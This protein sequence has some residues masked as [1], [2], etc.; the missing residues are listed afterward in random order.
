MEQPQIKTLNRE[1]LYEQVWSKPMIKLAREYG[2]SDNGLRNICR[3]LNVPMP[4]SGYWQQLQYGCEV[5]REPLP[6]FK[7]DEEVKIKQHP[8]ENKLRDELSESPE[9]VAEYLPE[10]QIKV[11]DKLTN[12]HPL[13]KRL[14]KNVDLNRKWLDR[15]LVY[16]VRGEIKI[17]VGPKSFDRALRIM[18][19]L[20]KALELRGLKASVD[21][22][23]EKTPAYV[24]VSGEKIIFDMYEKVKQ[25]KAA[26][27]DTFG[28]SRMDFIPTG[29][30]ILRINDVWD[31]RKEWGDG[32]QKPLEDLLNSF[33]R[34]L[35][36]AAIFKRNYRIKIEQAN[37]EWKEKLRLEEEKRKE[38]EQELGKIKALESQAL[39][40][41]KGKIIKAYIEE[42]K[43]RYIQ[44]HGKIEVGNEFEKWVTWAEN[45]VKQSDPFELFLSKFANVQGQKQDTI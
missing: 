25:A 10:N 43:K 14:K 16:R 3:K 28:Y 5:K 1:Q 11:A 31:V 33:I 34:G 2:L 32:S 39:S 23:A 8:E 38:R 35:Y 7:G 40:W 6:E 44:T 4:K 24:E 45:Y 12:P 26:E 13:I 27:R 29:N 9:I 30:L 20:L 37:C 21:S 41:D 19:T 15:G 18:D 22:T 42:A 17:H 36:K